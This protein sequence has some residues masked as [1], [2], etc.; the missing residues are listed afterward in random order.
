V[1][2]AVTTRAKRVVTARIVGLSHE[3]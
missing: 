2:R 3:P 1:I